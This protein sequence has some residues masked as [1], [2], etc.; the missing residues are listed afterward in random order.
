MAAAPDM[1]RWL[2]AAKM[3]VVSLANGD[4]Y[5]LSSS[6]P[7]V[8]FERQDNLGSAPKTFTTFLKSHNAY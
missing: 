2:H 1:V 4:V 3:L 6:E 8:A 7:F 5:S